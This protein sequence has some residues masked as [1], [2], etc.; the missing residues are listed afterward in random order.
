MQFQQLEYFVAIA[1]AGSLNKASEKLFLTQPSLSTAIANLEDEIN[2]KVFIRSKS[3][4]ELTEEGK[5][6]YHYA[7]AILERT[8]LIY[9]L[10]QDSSEMPGLIT[11]SSYPLISMGAWMAD[12]YNMHRDPY[13]HIDLKECRAMQLMENVENGISEIGFMMFN[14]AQEKE[15]QYTLRTK[16]LVYHPLG[17]DSWYANVGPSHPLYNREEV[18]MQE[19]L[20]YP[21]IRFQDDFFSNLTFFLEIDGIKLNN[22][23]K[24]LHVNDTAAIISILLNTD[25]FR[26][27]PKISA[28][29]FLKV[30]IRTI[31]I[32][33]CQVR[34]D[35]GWIEQRMVTHS[36]YVQ[37][38]ISLLEEKC[39]GLTKEIK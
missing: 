39:A 10:G 36:Q 11:V 38:F 17:Y 31:P 34:I 4:V 22:F 3:G 25:A 35:V 18:S 30:G 21:V 14:Q 5:K 9:R 16:K 12:Y 24:V 6:L 15:I 20:E 19:L 13:I 37:D 26:F 32:R 1:D 8:E 29:D 27:G 2:V 28:S 7:K 23:E 33:N